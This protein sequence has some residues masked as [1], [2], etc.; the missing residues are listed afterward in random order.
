MARVKTYLHAYNVGVHDGTAL[1]RVDLERMRLAAEEQTNMLPFATGPGVMR[2]GLQYLGTTDTNAAGRMKEFVFGAT[3]AALME[4]TNQSLRIWNN[5]ALVTRVSVSTAV[6]NGD[7]SSGT[8]W[9][10]TATDGG[11][12]TISGGKLTL[13]AV[14]RGSKPTCVRSVTVSGGDQSTVHALR[15]IV[16]RGPVNFKLGTTSGGEELI[17]TTSLD[18]GTHSL[19]F[20]PGTGT[21]YPWFGTT[22]AQIKIVDA[23]SVE[24]SGV[25]E[26]PTP[27]PTA[28]LDTMRFSQS[29]DVVFVACRGYKPYKIERRGSESWSVAEYNSNN[30]PF[31]APSLLFAKLKPSITVGNGTL[32]ADVPFFNSDHVG[33]LFRLFHTGQRTKYTLSGDDIYT[34]SIRVNG[35]NTGHAFNVVRTGT[36]SGKLTLQR[37]LDGE[38]FGFDDVGSGETGITKEYTGN[39][40]TT[41]DPDDA[42]WNNV[43]HYYRIGFKAGDYTSGSAE[44]TLSYGGSGG[45]GICRI[46][47]ITSS[48]V[49]EMEVLRPF[50]GTTYTDSWRQGEWSDASIYPSA[51]ALYDGRLWWSGFDRIWGSVSDD[52]TNFD[53]D[54]EGDAGPI[55]RSIA[56]GGINETQWLLGLQ[57]LLIGTEGAIAVAK[58][59]SLDEPLTPTGFTIRDASSVGVAAVDPAKLD[60]RGL[61]VERAGRAVMEIVF[62]A[63]QAD[64]R[65]TQ[66]SKLTTALFDAGVR[67]IAVQRRPETRIWIITETGGCIC[68]VYEPDQEVIAFVPIETDGTF[69]S[70]AV[71]PSD[72]QDRVYFVI[73]RTVN[74]STVRY[75]E[76]MALDTEIK[77]GNLCK[78]MDAFTTGTASA[79]ATIPVGTHLIGETVVAWVNGAPVE[80]STGVRGEYVVD[81]SGNITLAGAVTGNWVA[82]LPYRLRYKSARLA[83]GASQGTSML[84]RK[85][86]DTIGLILTDFTRQGIKHGMSFDKLYRLPS[87]GS[88]ET[89]SNIV[90]DVEDIVPF[91][92]GGGWTLDS[93]V[94]F[95]VNSPYTATFCGMT[96]DIT[97]SG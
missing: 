88:G 87:K 51:V 70:A 92:A 79:T 30:G 89:L 93:R 69:E 97:T 27:W 3:D 41:N 50:T 9:T 61:T 66:L 63:G 8:G 72:A 1:A 7:F 22:T 94:H 85:E 62:D 60:G 46:T 86:V 26:V 15:I 53:E 96:L 54:F 73:N 91:S 28:A 58:A 11:T 45:V 31:S 68:C 57:R 74:G 90:N 40:T 13:A 67:S 42:V 17:S 6:T 35:V 76:K 12:A 43:V 75:L 18:T 16:D 71:L 65:V 80:T 49:A 21:I 81:G 77:P 47:S 95:E 83:Y 23:I 37:S 38:D 44:V 82:G 84:A 25:M 10:L 39:G 24:S 14:G 5:D 2:P 56:T 20:T 36:W 29:A 52:F 4:F 33:T 59:S 48:T 32:T 19:A 78:V 34:D 64:Y 55:S